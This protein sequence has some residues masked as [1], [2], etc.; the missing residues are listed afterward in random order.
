MPLLR[1]PASWSVLVG[2]FHNQNPDAV[3][4]GVKQ[5]VSGDVAIP[6]LG[7]PQPL[8]IQM[9]LIALQPVDLRPA[10]QGTDAYIAPLQ[11]GP[12]LAVRQAASGCEGLTVWSTRLTSSARLSA[13][14]SH[15][16]RLVPA[17][18]R[19]HLPSGARVQVIA[20][21]RV[22]AA[23][24]HVSAG[25]RAPHAAQGP[26]SRPDSKSGRQRPVPHWRGHARS[27]AFADTSN[28]HRPNTGPAIRL[29]H[30]PV[31]TAT[32]HMTF[33]FQD[34][35]STEANGSMP[36]TPPLKSRRGV[37]GG[38][39]PAPDSQPRLLAGPQP[40]R[41]T[42]AVLLSRNPA[43]S[44]PP[45]QGVLPSGSGILP[46][47]SGVL[48]TGPGRLAHRSK[49]CPPAQVLPTGRAS[50]LRRG[51]LSSDLPRPA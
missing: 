24:R 36:L 13:R 18:L 37:I 3:C 1:R 29:R 35:S 9:T 5:H 7:V 46:T 41:L 40:A 12:G 34:A 22:Q 30:G 8:R 47:G 4:D 48:P 20:P 28:Q 26:T 2:L 15:T 10:W 32:V 23:A 50:L 38:V 19:P 27:P 44:C 33:M 25:Q 21:A 31:P 43:Q 42:V 49:S 6:S 11:P 51:R 17:W 14:L 16:R 39:C 45:A